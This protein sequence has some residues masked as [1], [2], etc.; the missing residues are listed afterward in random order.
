MIS[1]NEFVARWGADISPLVRFPAESLQTLKISRDDREFLSKAGLPKSA[2]SWIGFH[3]PYFGSWILPEDELPSEDY[4]R[5]YLIGANGCGDPI[6]IDGTANGQVVELFHEGRYARR[7]MN[8]SVRHLAACLLAYRQFVVDTE[9]MNGEDAYLSGNIPP[10]LRRRVEEELVSIDPA[11]MNPGS[12]WREQ[13][14][15]M[16]Y[17]ISRYMAPIADFSK[18]KI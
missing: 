8:T 9:K 1:P 14:D 18:G 3:L 11:A 12:F 7:F 15:S 13:L 2:A 17:D 6:A 10:E 4:R 5:I 16:D